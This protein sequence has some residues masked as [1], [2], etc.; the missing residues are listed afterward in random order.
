MK[1]TIIIMLGLII[2]LLIAI[3]FW[4]GINFTEIKEK[5]NS[6]KNNLTLTQDSLK[7]TIRNISEARKDI[8]FAKKTIEQTNIELEQLNN[9]LK[10]ELIDI[11][12]SFRQLEGKRK[13]LA[14]KIAG[15]KNDI[16]GKSKVLKEPVYQKLGA[17][18]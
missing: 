3:S 9:K 15:I 1:K 14:E 5:V 18:K 16:P 4:G 6:V 12:N 8:T 10:K 13:L 17:E 2:V 7:I 11:E